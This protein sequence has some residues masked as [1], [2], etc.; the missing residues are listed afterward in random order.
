MNASAKITKMPNLKFKNH[1]NT[2]ILWVTCWDLC[3]LT[4]TNEPLIHQ[5]TSILLLVQRGISTT[6]FSTV[7][8]VLANRG[9]S[10]K[11]DTTVPLGLPA[12]FILQLCTY[13]TALYHS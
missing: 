2:R 4:N 6:M 7:F 10:W 9:T 8:S 1:F 3:L 5:R 13:S 12:K 11:G